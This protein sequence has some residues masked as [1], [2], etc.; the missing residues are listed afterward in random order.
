MAERHTQLTFE[1]DLTRHL[2]M[3][4]SP[5]TTTDRLTVSAAARALELSENRVRQLA[6]SGRLACERIGRIRVFRVVDLEE[7][8]VARAGGR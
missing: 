1:A 4:I 3:Q 2:S 6:D 8:R 7:L 5:V